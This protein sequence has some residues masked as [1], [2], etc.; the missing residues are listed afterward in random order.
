[1]IDVV[2]VAERIDA[3]SLE[4]TVVL[5]GMRKKPPQESTREFDAIERRFGP[6]AR[7]PA[8]LL[9]LTDLYKLYEYALWDRFRNGR[10]W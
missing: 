1:V 10:Y 6:R 4:T 9:V 3:I 5:P 8:L 7:I 2:C